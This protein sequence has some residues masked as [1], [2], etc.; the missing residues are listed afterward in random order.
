MVNKKGGRILCQLKSD[1]G[2]NLGAP[3]DLPLNVDK[4]GLEKICQALLPS[5]NI[6]ENVPYAFFIDNEEFVGTLEDTLGMTSNEQKKNIEKVTE[7]VYQPQALF[8][9][10]SIFYD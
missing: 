3:I 7:I 5:E 9:Y 4:I 6:D 2:S 10:D 8:K 1:T